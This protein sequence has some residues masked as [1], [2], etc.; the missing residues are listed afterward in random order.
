MCPISGG[1]WNNAANAGVWALNL[2]LVRAGSGVD[3]GFRSDLAS[4]YENREWGKGRC[5]LGLFRN[6]NVIAFR[7]GA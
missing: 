7:V 1:N 4:H 6:R 2:S 5:F 3:I